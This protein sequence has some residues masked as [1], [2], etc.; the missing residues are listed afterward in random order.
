MASGAFCVT[1]CVL[2][3]GAERVWQIASTQCWRHS[4]STHVVSDKDAR[5]ILATPQV[6]LRRNHTVPAQHS[7]EWLG[8]TVESAAWCS[9]SAPAGAPRNPYLV[10]V[11]V[12]FTRMNI[13]HAIRWTWHDHGVE[14]RLRCAHRGTGCP[15]ARESLP[16]SQLSTCRK[17]SESAGRAAHDLE[18][19]RYRQSMV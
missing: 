16:F 1:I 14:H 15:T 11:S 13:A 19:V 3:L 8:M 7:I 6:V 10:W 5:P 4:V 17:P 18:R 9:I 12:Q 2:H